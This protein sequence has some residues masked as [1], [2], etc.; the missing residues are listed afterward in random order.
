MPTAAVL[1]FP[2]VEP[3]ESI[4][5]ID[6][7]T[8]AGYN[9]TTLGVTNDDIVHAAMGLDIAPK[10]KLEN[11]V[12]T[13]YDIVVMPGGPGSSEE[14]VFQNEL[15]HRFLKKHNAQRK[16][17]GSICAGLLTLASAGILDDK[18]V[19][20]WP[21]IK[22][23]IEPHCRQYLEDRVVV[24]S[25]IVSSRGPGTAILFALTLIKHGQS[26]QVAEVT[27]RGILACEEDL[28]KL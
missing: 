27:G 12:D 6:L 24:D 9:V 3:I 2:G 8:R 7:L 5:C 17:I 20:S 1:L 16:I 11:K 26:K 21:T 15:V 25:N 23:R 13:L 18:I 19:T 28:K 14:A 4:T 10:S 22:E